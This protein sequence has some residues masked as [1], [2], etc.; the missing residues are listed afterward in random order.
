MFEL[1][2]FDW[3]E[4]IVADVLVQLDAQGF[5]CTYD[6]HILQAVP[7]TSKS[8]PSPIEELLRSRLV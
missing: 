7:R 2:V 3:P 4:P 6:G 1:Q 5:D 8:A